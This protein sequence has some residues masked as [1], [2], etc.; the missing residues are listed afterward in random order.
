MAYFQDVTKDHSRKK[1]VQEC[2]DGLLVLK[3]LVMA[4]PR[5]KIVFT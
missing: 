3:M 5:T 2:H 1:K 4:R